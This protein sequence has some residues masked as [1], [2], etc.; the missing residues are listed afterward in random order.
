[1]ALT[2]E[3]LF[4]FSVLY[5][6]L[7]FFGAISGDVQLISRPALIF[8]GVPA[9][10]TIGTT[11][12][13]G[14]ITRIPSISILNKYKL[15]D[16][17]LAFLLLIP[18]FFGGLIGAYL[19]SIASED[20]LR[21]L[22][23]IVIMIIGFNMIFR[24]DIGIKEK[25]VKISSKLKHLISIALVLVN[26]ILGTLIGGAS[27]LFDF[28]LINLYGKT[29]IQ[30]SSI[31]KIS[32]IGGAISSSIFFIYYGL[33]DWQ[34]LLFLVISGTIGTYFGTKFGLKRGNKLARTIILTIL[35]ISGIKLII[36]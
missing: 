28:I 33:I 2:P 36:I 18:S 31:R 3:Y 32:T 8:L 10:I 29:Y 16:W 25:D 1:M 21:I 14:L 17:K 22:L 6:V 7:Q 11:R 4:L 23:G 15:I 13:S 19:V 30:A 35:L 27:S 9:Q 26:S 34:L 24:A 12:V 5:G 20:L